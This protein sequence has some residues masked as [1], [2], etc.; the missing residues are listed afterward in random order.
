MQET[1]SLANHLNDSGIPEATPTVVSEHSSQWQKGRL[2]ENKDGQ[3]LWRQGWG[4][5]EAVTELRLWAET[6]RDL[7]VRASHSA[8]G[9]STPTGSLPGLFQNAVK[10]GG[11][12]LPTTPVLR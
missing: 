7:E 9:Q 4:P 12:A 8:S 3:V 5:A 11:K 6:S 1:A 2:E 10:S